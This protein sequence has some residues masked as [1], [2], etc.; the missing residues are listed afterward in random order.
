MRYWFM[1]VVAVLL[2]TDAINDS[3]LKVDL[4]QSSQFAFKWNLLSL[5]SIHTLSGAHKNEK[6]VSLYRFAFL[7]SGLSES[8]LLAIIQQ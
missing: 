4:K 8:L 5:F 3:L 6:C 7:P 2:Q 1:D